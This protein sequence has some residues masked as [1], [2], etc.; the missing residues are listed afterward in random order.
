MSLPSN[1]RWLRQD[2]VLA[3][4]EMQIAEHGGSLGIRDLD[5]LESAL[6]RPRNAAA[7]ADPEPSIP[8]LA[9][10]YALG[11]IRNHP[12]V[13]GNKR[14]GFVLLELFLELHNNELT[15]SDSE[16]YTTIVDIAAGNMSDEAFIAWVNDHSR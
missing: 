9:A 2:T 12:F 13:D 7:Y 10:L 15:A 4:H 14:V 11:I 8:M 6:A 5:L 3:I 16:C 1:I